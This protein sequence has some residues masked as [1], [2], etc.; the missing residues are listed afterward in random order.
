MNDAEIIERWR[1]NSEP[2]TRAVRE[3]RIGSRLLATDAAGVSAQLPTLAVGFLFSAIAGVVAIRFLLAYLRR[4][5]LYIFSAYC[6]AVAVLVFVLSAV[7][8]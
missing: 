5:S 7:R 3:G 2:W 4:H 8:G 1:A 6:V